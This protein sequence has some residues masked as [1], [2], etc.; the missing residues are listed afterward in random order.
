MP[1]RW[2]TYA[3]P[4]DHVSLNVADRAASIAWYREG[5]LGRKSNEAS[6]TT[7][8]CS[9]GEFACIAL[10]QARPTR[11]SERVHRPEARGVRRRRPDLERAGASA[12]GRGVEFRFD[13]HGTPTPSTFPIRTATSSS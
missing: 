13:D 9:W 10:F 7:G 11:R 6:E 2:A 12:R 1:E 4:V 3:R 8:P 5:G